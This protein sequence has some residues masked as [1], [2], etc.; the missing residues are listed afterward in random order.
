MKKHHRKTVRAW[1]FV[2]ITTK[3]RSFDF[4][5]VKLLVQRLGAAI[6]YRLPI[7]PLDPNKTRICRSV[8]SLEV[9]CN[10]FYYFFFLIHSDL[11]L[12]N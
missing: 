7:Q 2:P 8:Q 10:L 4:L 1:S 3:H 5:Q 11:K 9:L 6:K 12:G